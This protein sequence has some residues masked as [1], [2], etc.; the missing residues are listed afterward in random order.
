MFY[1]IIIIIFII[2]ILERRIELNTG[3]EG[4]LFLTPDL[5]V[6][7]LAI[8]IILDFTYGDILILILIK[9]FKIKDKVGYFV[10]N[11]ISSNDTY[12]KVI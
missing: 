2:N 9:D 6:A 12:L 10:I 4:I 5:I 11:N 8:I 1:N 3:L 7:I